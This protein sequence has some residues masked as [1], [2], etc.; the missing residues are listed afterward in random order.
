MEEIKYTNTNTKE[1]KPLVEQI[2]ELKEFKDQVMSGEIKSKRVKIPRKAKVT[3]RKLKKGFLGILKVDENRNISMEKQRIQGSA[4]STDDGIY[5][6]TDGSEILFWE[7]KFPVLI[8]PTW[9]T[10]PLSI[11]P[12]NEKNETYGDKYKMAK[13]L[14]DTIKVKSSGGSIVLWIILGIA[15]LIGVNYLMGG[16]LFG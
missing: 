8:Q 2:R 1:T 3:K 7:G 14:A 12:Q 10:N 5:H 4:Y 13:M 16:A 11:N 6:A 15:A 9:R